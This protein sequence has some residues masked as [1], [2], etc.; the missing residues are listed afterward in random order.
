[1]MFYNF[2]I[3]DEESEIPGKDYWKFL[4]ATAKELEECGIYFY[5]FTRVWNSLKNE[6]LKLVLKDER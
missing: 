1:M 6:E 4:D 5:D 3:Y 2:T